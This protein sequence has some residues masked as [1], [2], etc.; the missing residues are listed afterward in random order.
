MRRRPGRALIRRWTAL[1][2]SP[3]ATCAR[4]ASAASCNCGVAYTPKVVRA[5]EAIKANPQKSDRAIVDDIGVGKDTVRRA[6]EQGGAH[7]PPDD[8]VGRDGKSYPSSQPVRQTPSR[9]K[10]ATRERVLE[11]L[12]IPVGSA[13]SG[14]S[15]CS[16]CTAI[17]G[18]RWPDDV[19]LSDLEPRFTCQ[20]CG[21]RGAD[22]RPNF[23]WE[24]EARL[25]KVPAQ[26]LRLIG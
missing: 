20:A 22:V 4:P 15:R 5:A 19:R 21:K 14:R 8:R 6:R 7:A 13:A 11:A 10:D 25:A 16:H 26:P 17:S 23:D 1:R 24:K 3:S 18:D 2:K 9:G 12:M